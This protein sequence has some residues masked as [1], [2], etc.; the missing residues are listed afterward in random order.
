MFTKLKTLYYRL[1]HR[2]FTTLT[3]VKAHRAI[4]DS[5]LSNLEAQVKQLQF[6][7]LHH[8]TD[9]EGYSDRKMCYTKGICPPWYPTEK[10]VIDLP[11]GAIAEAHIVM[12]TTPSIVS[13][14]H[15]DA[16]K[17]LADHPTYK[18]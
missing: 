6:D 16:V 8:A 7:L 12:S 2:R 4:V 15:D 10:Q 5:R 11:D 17:A 1:T 3:S 9:Q 14:V 13:K 18:H